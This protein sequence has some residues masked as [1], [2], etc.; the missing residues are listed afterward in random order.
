MPT[1]RTPHY[2]AVVLTHERIDYGEILR[3]QPDVLAQLKKE[4]FSAARDVIEEALVPE[5]LFREGSGE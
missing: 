4:I 2:W 5:N 3:G 1:N